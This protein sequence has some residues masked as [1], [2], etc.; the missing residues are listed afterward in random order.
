M[1]SRFWVGPNLRPGQ[2]RQ[3][4]CHP[5]WLARAP[6]AQCVAR[7]VR[8]PHQRTPSFRGAR[9]S[10]SYSSLLCPWQHLGPGHRG[11]LERNRAGGTDPSLPEQG[12]APTSWQYPASSRARRQPGCSWASH[13]REVTGGERPGL[14][15]CSVSPRGL[16][17]HA[18]GREP[19]R[20]LLAAPKPGREKWR[21]AGFQESRAKGSL[22]KLELPLANWDGI[23]EKHPALPAASASHR[24]RGGRGGASKDLPCQD[25][26]VA[27]VAENTLVSWDQG[28]K[29]GRTASQPNVTPR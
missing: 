27:M 12:C 6:A 19:S 10:P 26:E 20:S 11:G 8:W 23:P 18:P 21:G 16:P 5:G 7:W 9:A 15:A 2:R 29:P 22:D 25:G 17:G 1:G 14:Q 13:S 24:L 4:L 3:P 28:P